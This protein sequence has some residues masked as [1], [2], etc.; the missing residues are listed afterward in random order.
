MTKLLIVYHS[1]SGNTEAMAKAFCEGAVSS[2][3]TVSLQKAADTTNADLIDCDALA[4]GTANYFSYM[5]G[6]VKD[7]F[8][9]TFYAVRGKADDKPYIVF[10][11][12]GGGG[13]KALEGVERIC[14]ALNFRKA[15]DN[16]SAEGKPSSDVLE[17]CKEIGR[18]LAEL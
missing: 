13:D 15:F 1:Q 4:I 12:H 3:V 2:G 14:T 5:A 16:V 8:D 11:S 7:L 6:A 18:K 17:Q 10:G 9:R